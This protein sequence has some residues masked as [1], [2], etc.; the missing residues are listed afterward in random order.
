MYDQAQ[1]VAN[2]PQTEPV[3]KSILERFDKQNAWQSEE[4]SMIENKLHDILNK[5]SPE[6]EQGKPEPSINDLSQAFSKGLSVMES[7]CR[8]LEIINKHLKEI[9]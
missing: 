7:N 9:F 5:R 3:L 4:L 6:K 1:A 8:R 2:A